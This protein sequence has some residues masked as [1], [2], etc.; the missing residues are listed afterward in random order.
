VTAAEREIS[1]AAAL[2]GLLLAFAFG[3]LA[4]LVPTT[5]E[6][7]HRA[8]PS[9]T[10]DREALASRLSAYRWLHAGLVTF[11]VLLCAAL[12]PVTTE[13]IGRFSVGA[14][15]ATTDAALLLFDLML[16]SLAAVNA[17]LAL[18]LG[19]RVRELRA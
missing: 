18:R 5:V 11:A 15:Y 19:R 3:Y 7:L 14:G 2:L 4:A 8:R 10:A 17:T 9:V 6:L 16:L 12:W 13:V 1:D